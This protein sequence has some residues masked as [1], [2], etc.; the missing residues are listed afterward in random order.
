MTSICLS[1]RTDQSEQLLRENVQ[2]CAYTCK[3]HVID[4]KSGPLALLITSKRSLER[5]G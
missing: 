2:L 5:I 3:R 4:E 1:V